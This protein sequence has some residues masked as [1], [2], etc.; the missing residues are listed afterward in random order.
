VTTN[1]TY[2]A[3]II[4]TTEF[5][6]EQRSHRKIQTAAFYTFQVTFIDKTAAIH[7]IH[8]FIHVGQIIPN[9]AVFI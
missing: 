5:K 3:M 8:V 9:D 1:D 7:F 4:N 6:G 2:S